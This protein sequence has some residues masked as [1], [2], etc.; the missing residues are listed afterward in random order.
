MLWNNRPSLVYFFTTLLFPYC[1]IVFIVR[2]HLT[3]VRWLELGLA[4]GFRT[5]LGLGE[6]G[7]GSAGV[8]FRSRLKL[9]PGFGRG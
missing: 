9:E 3:G 7:L 4:I 8:R 5:R 1:Y 2:Y 6:V